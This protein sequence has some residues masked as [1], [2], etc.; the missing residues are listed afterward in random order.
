[1]IV[2]DGL[3]CVCVCVCESIPSNCVG[4]DSKE[5]VRKIFLRQENE[6]VNDVF[7]RQGANDRT[8]PSEQQDK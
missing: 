5:K 6:I 1:M 8:S 3:P 7:R 2:D 4:I